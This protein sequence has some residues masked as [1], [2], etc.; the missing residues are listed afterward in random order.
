MGWG[1]QIARIKITNK[2]QQKI[3]SAVKQEKEF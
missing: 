2:I 3:K 1:Q